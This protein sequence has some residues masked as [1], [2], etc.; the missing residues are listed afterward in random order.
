[1]ML[2]SISHSHS[3]SRPISFRRLGFSHRQNLRASSG[4]GDRKYLFHNQPLARDLHPEEWRGLNA[5]AQC[6]LDLGGKPERLQ[7]FLDHW[8]GRQY[9]NQPEE[10]LDDLPQQ[11]ELLKSGKPLRFGEGLLY[12]GALDVRNHLALGAIQPGREPIFFTRVGFYW[13]NFLYQ[14]TDRQIP[15]IFLFDAAFF[16]KRLDQGKAEMEIEMFDPY[17]ETAHEISLSDILEVWIRRDGF[18][19][20]MAEFGSRGSPLR[21]SVE[22]LRK[23]NALK[24]IDPLP[25]PL[26]PITDDMEPIKIEVVRWENSLLSRVL[27]QNLLSRI[28]L[29]KPVTE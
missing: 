10:L 12:H 5:F 29:F 11:N 3:I 4:S 22:I 15:G 20:M 1:M 13:A 27:K 17:M 25:L 24:L 26:R 8:E 14:Q 28:P 6:F 2:R 19:K 18:E 23:R 16:N 7:P 21:A 9:S